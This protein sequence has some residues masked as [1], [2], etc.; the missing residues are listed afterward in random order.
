MCRDDSYYK[1]QCFYFEDFYKNDVALDGKGYLE[2]VYF[3]GFGFYQAFGIFVTTVDDDGVGF[4]RLAKN[5]LLFTF[6]FYVIGF[7]TFSFF[8]YFIYIFFSYFS[9]FYSYF[10]F[11]VSV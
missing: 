6:G 5:A 9:Y 7:Y 4:F 10:T 2:V 1:M 11:L 8:Y 3:E